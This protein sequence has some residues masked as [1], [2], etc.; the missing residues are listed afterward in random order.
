[1]VMVTMMMVMNGFDIDFDGENEFY[2]VNGIA[3][4][5]VE[6]PIKFKVG[7]LIRIY[8]LFELNNRMKNN[9]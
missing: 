6:Y 5:Y 2:T 8:L 7:E 9:D 3:N 1:M 4:Y